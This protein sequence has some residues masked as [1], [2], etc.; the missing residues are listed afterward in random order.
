[1]FLSHWNLGENSP[2][3]DGELEFSDRLVPALE[4]A[5]EIVKSCYPG[6]LD[7]GCCHPDELIMY[8]NKMK[9][10]TSFHYFRSREATIRTSLQYFADILEQLACQEINYH[11]AICEVMRNHQ[12]FSAKMDKN[13]ISCS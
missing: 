9:A 6:M 3:R 10:V 11:L 2:F 13:E 1:M 12:V 7:L 4:V 8:L 5:E